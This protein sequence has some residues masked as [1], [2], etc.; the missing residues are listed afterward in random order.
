MI[1]NRSSNP[2][3]LFNYFR[4]ITKN[5]NKYIRY[6]MYCFMYIFFSFKTYFSTTTFCSLSQNVIWTKINRNMLVWTYF[7]H[8]YIL[9]TYN[10]DWKR[11]VSNVL[12]SFLFVLRFVSSKSI[13]NF[14]EFILCTIDVATL[15][16]L[17][18]VCCAGD[19]PKWLNIMSQN[20]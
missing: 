13:H 18:V 11:T 16:K 19:P 8:D 7:K 1:N 6:L 9:S 10:I 4:P 20:Y 3:N 17:W 5:K 2:H 14:I 12:F 15:H